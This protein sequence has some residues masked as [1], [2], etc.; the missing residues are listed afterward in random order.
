M[1]GFNS[2]IPLPMDLWMSM[3]KEYD[4]I[5]EGNLDKEQG[6]HPIYRVIYIKAHVRTRQWFKAGKTFVWNDGE[7]NGNIKYK[8]MKTNRKIL[9]IR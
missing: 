1:A 8:A 7:E 4:K 5:Y 9:E 3:E 6:S 2:I